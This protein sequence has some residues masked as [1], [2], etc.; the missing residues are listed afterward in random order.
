MAGDVISLSFAAS[1][2]DKHIGTAKPVAITGLALG[3][4]DAGNYALVGTIG[5]TTAQVTRLASVAW[6]G[7]ASGDWFNPANWANGAVPDRDNVAAVTIAVGTSARFGTTPI[8]PAEAGPV[9]LAAL[10][11]GF[12]LNFLGGSLT[13]AGDLTLASFQQSGGHLTVGNDFNVSGRF[14]QGAVG[15]VNVG[16]NVLITS[17]GDISLGNLT[18]LGSIAAS[19]T[20]GRLSLVPATVLSAGTNLRLTPDPRQQNNGYFPQILSVLPDIQ[21]PI[22]ALTAAPVGLQASVAPPASPLQVA[23]VPVTSVDSTVLSFGRGL[24]I[25]PDKFAASPIRAISVSAV[26]GFVPERHLMVCA[27][28]PGLDIKI[29]N[30]NGTVSI[31]GD[32]G[33]EDYQRAVKSL[34]LVGGDGAPLRL[35]V[36]VTVSQGKIYVY[37]IE[38]TRRTDLAGRSN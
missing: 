27:P 30:I 36:Q 35:R 19:T 8:A 28:V 31:S 20:A 17:A 18:A 33:A 29:D 23:S 16:R 3:G 2:A 34:S 37:E 5:T 24:F 21:S 9:S 10:A 13:V 6:V 26:S 1:L 14:D 25:S 11:G 4:A 12:D 7:G 32:A 22:V 15:G 38:I